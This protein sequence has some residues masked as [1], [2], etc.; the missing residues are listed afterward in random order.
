[1]N[2]TSDRH[3]EETNAKEVKSWTVRRISS[4]TINKAKKEADKRGMKIGPWLDLQLST[5]LE[6]QDSQNDSA[7]SNEI[8]EI[9]VSS[10]YAFAD[11]VMS[12]IDSLSSEI[13]S[14]IKG[15][16]SLFLLIS[17]LIEETKSADQ[18]N[19]DSEFCS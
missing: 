3:P 17:N 14:I 7:V 2:T 5:L 19:S 16:H 4:D 10:E 8:R 18:T 12:E 9:G 1:M 15:Q 6:S 11:R 13:D